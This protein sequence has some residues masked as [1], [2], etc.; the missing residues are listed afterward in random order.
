MNKYYQN[1]W[2]QGM[3]AYQQQ[4]FKLDKQI[5]NAGDTRRGITLLARLSQPVKDKTSQFLTELDVICPGQYLYPQSDM[6]LTIMSIVSCCEGFM[7]D[8]DTAQQYLLALAPKLAVVSSFNVEFSGI[9]VSDAAVLLAGHT[10]Q[11]QL[12]DL[13]SQVREAITISGT[14]HSMDS[15]YKIETAHSTI[16]RYQTQPTNSHSLIQFLQKN[17]HRQFT[18]MR[19]GSLDLVFNDWYQTKKNTRLIGHIDLAKK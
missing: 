16:F 8:A 7:F 3:A 14:A 9:T 10:D 1:M 11:L 13:R 19:V 2:Q 17:H 6:H 4:E 15:R 18:H 12:A 5:A